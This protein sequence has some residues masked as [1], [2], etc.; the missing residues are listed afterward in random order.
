MKTII[1]IL[2]LTCISLSANAKTPL[3]KEEAPLNLLEGRF[4]KAKPCT[5][6]VGIKIHGKL[7]KAPECTKLGLSCLKFKPFIEVKRLEPGVYDENETVL[8]FEILSN[9]M[10]KVSFNLKHQESLF[11]VNEAFDVPKLVAEKF[12]FAS[13]QILPGNYSIIKNRDG[14][15]SINVKIKTR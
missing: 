6:T 1:S 10:M 9:K 4:E 11:D 14:S 3:E 13:I 15:Y 5:V 8:L 2:L 12:G 7:R